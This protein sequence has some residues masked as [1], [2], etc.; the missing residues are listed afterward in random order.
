MLKRMPSF[1]K[2]AD[3]GIKNTPFSWGNNE[4][5]YDQR[6]MSERNPQDVI[7]ERIIDLPHQS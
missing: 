7:T 2:R 4:A 6:I 3:D 1:R 5:E